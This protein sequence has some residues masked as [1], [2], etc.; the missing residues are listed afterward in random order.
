MKVWLKILY[1]WDSLKFKGF[2]EEIDV[3]IK[4]WYLK[5]P[6]FEYL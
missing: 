2:D 4:Y 1:F 5:Q 3:K 6:F